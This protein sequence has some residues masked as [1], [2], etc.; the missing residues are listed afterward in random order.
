MDLGV[1]SDSFNETALFKARKFFPQFLT[2]RLPTGFNETAL[3]KARKFCG[4]R[5]AKSQLHRFNET[6]LFKARKLALAPRRE[7]VP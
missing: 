6:A 1:G 4:S 5:P 3:F 2:P 7:R